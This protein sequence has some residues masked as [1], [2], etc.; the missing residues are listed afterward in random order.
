MIG[1]E[2]VPARPL[3][4]A[5]P[6][7]RVALAPGDRAL[8]APGDAVEMGAPLVERLRD[9]RIE[10]VPDGGAAAAPGDRVDVPAGRSGRSRRERDGARDLGELLF[11]DGGRRRVVTGD[12]VD[13]VESPGPGTVRAVHQASE[14]ELE[15][16]GHAV[17]GVLALGVPT[18]GRLEIATDEAGELRPGSIDVGRAGTILVVGS[19]IDAETLTRA[20]AMGVRGIVVSALA[21]KEERDFA[22]SERRQRAAIHQLPPVGVLVLDG[23][24]RRPIA[25]SVMAVLR[26]LAGRDVGLS[27]DPP[28]LLFPGE[29]EVGFEPDAV[30]VRHG[31]LAGREGRWAGSAGLRRFP[32]GVHLESGFVRL[33]DGGVQTIPLADLERFV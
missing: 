22:A 1:F 20:R 26:A 16:A 23:A 7:V 6:R 10:L 33:D 11:V 9:A 3:A 5:R 15:I 4:V 32:G 13:I 2:L 21:A 27:I 31:P 14:L 28:A 30:R 19:R 29:V 12:H 25:S 18:H 24:I 8:V 17:P